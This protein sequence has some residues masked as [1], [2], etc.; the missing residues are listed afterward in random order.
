[1]ARNGGRLMRNLIQTA[2]CCVA[3][4][5]AK[6][7]FREMVL[8]YHLLQRNV[9]A[10]FT[11]IMLLQQGHQLPCCLGPVEMTQSCGAS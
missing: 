3:E 1:M 4:D 10:E 7:I 9:V 11:E 5:A 8:L 2:L 6:R